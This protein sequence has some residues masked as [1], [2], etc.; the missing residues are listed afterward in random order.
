MEVMYSMGIGVAY[1]SSI[2][3][4]FNIVLD[5][6][7]MFYEAAVFLSS[8]LMLGKYLE[9]NAKGRTSD[10]IKSLMGLQVKFAIVVRGGAKSRPQSLR[11]R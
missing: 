4:T 5:N 6:T 2:M 1:I 10:A 8:F 3:G 9:A 7:F 11:S